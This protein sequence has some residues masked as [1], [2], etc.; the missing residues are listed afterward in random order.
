ME[1]AMF[2]YV[3][4]KILPNQA[5]TFTKDMRLSDCTDRPCAKLDILHRGITLGEGN[6]TQVL[7]LGN[8]DGCAVTSHGSLAIAGGGRCTTRQVEAKQHR[9]AREECEHDDRQHDHWNHDKQD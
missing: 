2:H 6:V 8:D 5:V 4:G 3:L 9:A 7:I 1:A